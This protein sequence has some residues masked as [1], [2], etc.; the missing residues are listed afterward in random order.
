MY[1][2]KAGDTVLWEMPHV[3]KK[4]NVPCVR[5]PGIPRSKKLFATVP[6]QR[7]DMSTLYES[8]DD[9]LFNMFGHLL[10]RAVNKADDGFFEKGEDDPPANELGNAFLSSL[11]E[12]CKDIH[13]KKMTQ[14]HSAQRRIIGKAMS[15]ASPG[16]PFD[17]LLGRYCF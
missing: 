16:Q 6:F 11:V 2:I 12:A 10:R 3:D 9:E 7:K 13:Y 8:L 1:T 5:I 15:T 14:H 4:R 17:I